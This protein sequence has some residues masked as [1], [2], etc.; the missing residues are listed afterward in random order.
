MTETV[1]SWPGLGLYM[2][3][4]LFNADLNAV[5]GGTV[6]VGVVYICLNHASPTCCTRWSIRAPE[7][8]MSATTA[9]HLAARGPAPAS[10]RQA[11]FGRWFRAWRSFSGNG[12][13]MA[14]LAIV[15]SLVLIAIFA[16]L[17][18]DPQ[19]ATLQNLAERL[20]PAPRPRTGSA[21][22]NW[23]A[24]SLPAP[25]SARASR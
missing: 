25:C 22:T 13:A 1:F 11:R 9:A 12:L 5:L 14:G 10:R 16:P 17:I 21:P 20:Q 7:V 4:S 2:K 19:A 24:T 18:A 15:L 3:N 23:A 6:L 8:A